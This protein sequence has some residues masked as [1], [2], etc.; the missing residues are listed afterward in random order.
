MYSY[1]LTTCFGLLA[2][3]KDKRF[4]YLA[5]E[6]DL[7]SLAIVW[8]W[9]LLLG[10]VSMCAAVYSATVMRCGVDMDWYAVTFYNVIC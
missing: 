9:C 1:L 3:L 8:I 5:L 10:Y 2:I 4:Y 7:L 6:S